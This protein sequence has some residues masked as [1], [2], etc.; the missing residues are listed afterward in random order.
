MVCPST[1]LHL[2][3]MASM[4]PPTRRA[5]AIRDSV[6]FTPPRVLEK[7]GAMIPPAGKDFPAQASFLELDAGALAHNAQ[8]FRELIGPRVRLGAV[9][10]GNAYGHGFA[11]LLPHAHALA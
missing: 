5:V 4:S 2:V 6:T 10:K 3:H 9:L 11:E 8:V 7:L 1:I